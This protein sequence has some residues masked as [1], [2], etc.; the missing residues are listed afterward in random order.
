MAKAIVR[1][2]RANRAIQPVTT[3]AYLGY[4]LWRLSPTV[5]KVIARLSGEGTLRYVEN[6]SLVRT[7][8]GW[9]KERTK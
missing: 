5:M 3:E 4:A 2:V 9:L 1:S 7:A 6:T 8:M